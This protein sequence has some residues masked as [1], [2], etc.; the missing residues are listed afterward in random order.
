MTGLG[1][2]C[3]ACKFLR[4]KCASECVFA[5]YFC[6]DEAAD[7]FAAVHKVF[8]A[9]NVSKLLLHLPIHN[10]RDAALT[11]AYE[12]LARMRDPIY[13]C[14]AHIFALQQQVA[15]LQEEIDALVN[16]MANLPVGIPSYG[17]PQVT[18]CSDGLLQFT[19]QHGTTESPC[20]QDQ[21]LA[22]PIHPD[23][24]TEIQTLDWQINTPVPAPTLYRQEDQNSFCNFDPN[25]PQRNFQGVETDSI[26]AAWQGLS[27]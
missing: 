10:R 9:S 19:T 24:L 12:A 4:R 21:Q 16:Q 20:H 6:Y 1:S 17:N 11:V 25:P 5:P 23:Y 27:W 8:G 15:H 14:V 3:G 13:G 18:A 22:L 2:S 26:T 7:H